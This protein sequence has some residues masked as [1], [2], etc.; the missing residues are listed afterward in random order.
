MWITL[1]ASLGM[2]DEVEGAEGYSCA[3]RSRDWAWAVGEKLDRIVRVGWGLQGVRWQA[4]GQGF[5]KGLSE[6]GLIMAVSY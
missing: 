4:G 1:G 3:V 6:C 2:T 5:R